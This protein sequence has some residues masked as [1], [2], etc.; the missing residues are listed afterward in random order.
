MFEYVSSRATREKLHDLSSFSAG[1]YV[2][3]ILPVRDQNNEYHR[4]YMDFIGKIKDIYRGSRIIVEKV[5]IFTR[6]E[7][8]K[9]TSVEVQITD[10]KFFPFWVRIGDLNEPF[11]S[12]FEVLLL[13]ILDP[14]GAGSR[15]SLSI[16]R[17]DG[18]DQACRLRKTKKRNKEGQI[19]VKIYF[20][21]KENIYLDLDAANL[22]AFAPISSFF[23]LGR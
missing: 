23:H 19:V 10:P 15:E 12:Q 1:N 21:T 2:T 22:I 18:R 20:P 5:A 3:E 16:F 13:D 14:T 4:D 17:L 9:T 6:D 11:K 7:L 8:V